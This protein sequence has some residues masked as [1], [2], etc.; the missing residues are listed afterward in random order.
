MA[1]EGVITVVVDIPMV[2]ITDYGKFALFKHNSLCF[3]LDGRL[4][5]VKGESNM[6]AVSTNKDEFVEVSG[7]DFHSCL[8]IGSVFLCH[9]LGVKLSTSFP[10]CLCDIFRGKTKEVM[11]DCDSTFLSERF[12]LDQINST[13][14]LYYANSSHS[15]L[16]SCGVSQEQLRLTDFGVRSLDPGCVL[17]VAGVTFVSAVAPRVG[18]QQVVTSFSGNCLFSDDIEALNRSLSKALEDFHQIDYNALLRG[19]GGALAPE[20]SCA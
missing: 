10:C 1:K 16:L 13:Y 11:S 5:G 19:G 4:V 12:R 9:Y 3:Q 8:H 15:G 14:F 7:S 20:T 6:V 2:P 18:V 17:T